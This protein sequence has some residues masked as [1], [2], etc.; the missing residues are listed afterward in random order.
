MFCM[1]EGGAEVTQEMKLPKFLEF[2][3]TGSGGTKLYGFALTIYESLQRPH[4][5]Q[6]GFKS[7]NKPPQV[8]KSL[9]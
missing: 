3:S 9:W 7:K 8:A 6:L 5:K 4:A 1:P 2:V